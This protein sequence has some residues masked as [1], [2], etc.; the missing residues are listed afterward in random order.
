[1]MTSQIFQ[2]EKGPLT[3][4]IVFPWAQDSNCSFPNIGVKTNPVD[5][6]S[7]TRSILECYRFLVFPLNDLTPT[8]PRPDK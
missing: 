7:H 8:P 5:T 1:M 6:V 4:S 3:V 2:K